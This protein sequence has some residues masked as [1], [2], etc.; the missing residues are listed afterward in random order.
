MTKSR[1]L[2]YSALLLIALIWGAAF[3]IIKPVFDLLTPMQYLYFRFL[4]AGL[5]ALPIFLYFY[6]KIR[7][8]ISYLLKV[9]GIELLG[10]PLPLLI[11]YE[12][13][14][15][16]ASLD[17]AL[18]G[19]T[20]PIFVVLGGILFLHERESKREWQGLALSLAGSLMIVAEPLI[21]GIHADT[22]GSATGN[23]LILSYNIL[24]AV[25]ALIAKRAY[26]KKPPLY[27]GSLTYLAT[28]LIYGLIL[29]HTHAIPDFH[30][31]IHPSV[32]VP[33]LYMALPGGILSFFLYLYAQSKIEVSEANLFTYL[34]GV[35]AIPA[36]YLI[37]GE[38]PSLFTIV[39]ICVV[40]LGVYRAEVRSSQ[41]K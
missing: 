16:T 6:L 20:G 23:L 37:L 40:A 14:S 10:I 8:K 28:A 21:F 1:K 9:L 41:R 38:Q 11:L 13:L 31:L 2:A 17:A 36:A 18:I 26:K 29:S 7:P 25:Y 15:R 35:V 4:A 34:D 5:F 30:L 39:A 3:P 33:V 22:A 24:W 27:L 12:G 32:Y 19:A